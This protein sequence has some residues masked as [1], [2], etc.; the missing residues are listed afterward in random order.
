MQQRV[1]QDLTVGCVYQRPTAWP[2]S[3]R[4][5]S[6]QNDFQFSQLQTTPGVWTRESKKKPELNGWYIPV[7]LLDAGRWPALLE[8]CPEEPYDVAPSGLKLQRHQARSVSFLRQIT[9][10]R[11]GALL[12]AEMGLGKSC[13]ALH[14]L[15]LDGFLQQPGVVIAPKLARGVWC[16]EDSDAYRH[17][18]LKIAPVEGVKNMDLSILESSSCIFCNYEILS[19]WQTW[20]FH[21]FKPAWLIA[22][23]IHYCI[24]QKAQRAKAA[25]ELALCATIQ[26]RIGLT[27]TPLPNERMDLWSQLAIVQP[28][29]WGTTKHFFGLRYC[30]GERLS[31]EQGGHWDY[32]GESNNEELRARLAG[33]FLC[34]M[35]EDITDEMPPLHRHI[36]EANLSSSPLAD[37][38]SLAQRD[39]AAYLKQKGALPATTQALKI[40][41]QTVKLSKNDRKPGATRLVCLTTLIGI[42]SEMKRAAALE[43]IGSILKDHNR[44]V[45][46]SLR[47][48]TAGWIYDQLIA[49]L[50]AGQTIG[51]KRPVVYGPVHGEMAMSTRK[52]LAG[53]FA[54]D[55]AS[56]Y[57]A[58]VG[59]AGT[60][61]NDLS[62]A[63]AVLMVDLHWNTTSLRQAEKR[64][65]RIGCTAPKVD[66]YYLIAPKTVDDLFLEKID[67]K[68]QVAHGVSEKDSGGM[69]LVRDLIPDSERDE[70]DLDL[71]CERLMDVA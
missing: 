62:A 51:G 66:A 26:R 38:Y 57:V 22:D 2:G 50:K 54:R 14:A 69:G 11:E 9:A 20:I 63:S 21:R 43:A 35:T 44:L 16:D 55:I 41:S 19:S 59:G 47:R 37:E 3:C 53:Q 24:H 49:L 70:I 36:L 15:W 7:S 39:V 17:Y 58:T 5:L 27:G 60:S 29:Q 30:R 46:F 52:M 56:V 45:V 32:S 8:Q 31:E 71:L 67:W 48:K 28:R 10:E 68:A 40:G 1:H 61:I 4:L 33:T 13:S 6:C 42:V 65:H 64:I 34:Y 23:E 25:R 18:G 12:V